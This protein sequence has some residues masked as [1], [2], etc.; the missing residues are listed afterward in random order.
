[1]AAS[2][3]SLHGQT[4]SSVPLRNNTG[5]LIRSTG[6]SASGGTVLRLTSNHCRHDVPSRPATSEAYG[7]STPARVKLDVVIEGSG[8]VPCHTAWLG[9]Q[10]TTAVIEGNVAPTRSAV[11][12]PRDM[13]N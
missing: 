10:A 1:M 8:L 11:A 13:P 12:P 9:T 4:P 5:P 7:S 3:I 6:I 2:A